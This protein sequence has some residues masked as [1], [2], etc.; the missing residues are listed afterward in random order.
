MERELGFL[1]DQDRLNAYQTIVN[2]CQHL[3][4]KGKLVPEKL[5]P[6]LD[7]FMVL[8]EKDPYFLAHFT[9]YAV[10]KLDSK[11]LKVVSIFVNSLS[12]ADGTA[13]YLSV[14]LLAAIG[15]GKC[16]IGI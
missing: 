15:T 11:D 16:I 6:V 4:S 10:K 1:S 5:N 13:F 9:S 14:L 2:G 12:D 8:A 3:W 7:T